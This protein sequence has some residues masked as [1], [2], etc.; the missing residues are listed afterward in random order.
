LFL[1]LVVADNLSVVVDQFWDKLAQSGLPTYVSLSVPFFFSIQLLCDFMAY[2]DIARG[3]AYQLGFRLPINFNAPYLATSFSN[4]WKRWH[5]TLSNWF[6][7]YIYIPLG[8]SRRGVVV[9]I[10]NITLVF[11]V[12][13]LWHGANLIF[14]VWGCILSIALVTE[15]LAIRIWRNIDSNIFRG[16]I[17]K[18]LVSSSAL[19]WYFVVQLVWI[20]SLISFRS[21]EINQAT[22]ILVS[23][24]EFHSQAEQTGREKYHY[25]LIGWC[26]T[27]PV[28]LMHFQTFLVE[29][30]SRLAILREE[31]FIYA[32]I[33]LGLICAVYGSPRSFIYF[34]F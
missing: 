15:V 24:S 8:E 19:A 21:T 7:H 17:G 25:V 22:Q 3:I 11:L 12:S 29:R 14:I 5:I 28:L 1:K 33:M 6:K 2:T 23:L 32:G 26:L 18:T 31:R 30:D 4:F 27:I 13:G 10:F 9:V 20:F 16:L 34:Q